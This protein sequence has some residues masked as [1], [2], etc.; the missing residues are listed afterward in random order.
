MA[1]ASGQR[2]LQADLR[3]ESWPS[4]SRFFQSMVS[5]TSA[6]QPLDRWIGFDSMFGTQSRSVDTS[7]NKKQRKSCLH[8]TI[9]VKV[10]SWASCTHV[11]QGCCLGT[12]KAF[13]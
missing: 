12:S 7:G 5:A 8:S 4:K 10:Y 2:R 3:M 6:W 9:Q 13:E 1:V 11:G